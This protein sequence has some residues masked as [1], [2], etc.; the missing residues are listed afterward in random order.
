MSPLNII[1][2][3]VCTLLDSEDQISTCTFSAKTLP[4]NL[5]RPRRCVS[6]SSDITTHDVLHRNEYS[7]K[8]KMSSWYCVEEIKEIK[9]GVKAIVAKMMSSD[10]DDELYC[11]RGLEARTK[12]GKLRKRQNKIGARAAAFFEQEA[13]QA[14]GISDPE[15]IAD[16][17]YDYSEHCQASAEMM[18]L[19]DE[20]DAE[21]AWASLKSDV[22]EYSYSRVVLNLQG[23][24]DVTIVLSSA[25]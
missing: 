3:N 1:D 12:E 4:L 14:E 19:R 7:P 25:A 2:A 24:K 8:E 22:L 6:F 21:H 16:V 18:G 13:Q 20:K 15:A 11:T 23:T 5:E 9:D 10:D 17:Y